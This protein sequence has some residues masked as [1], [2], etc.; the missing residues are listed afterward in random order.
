MKLYTVQ[1][2]TH[3]HEATKKGILTGGPSLQHVEPDWHK[4]YTWMREQMR[5]KLATMSGD[6]PVWAWPWEAY[7]ARFKPD[8][9]WGAVGEEM[10]VLGLDVPDARVLTSD[11]QAWHQVL[12]NDIIDDKDEF[13]EAE[14]LASW[15]LIFNPTELK[16]G[17]T[18]GKSV[19]ACVDQ[20][21]VSE[22]FF[23]QIFTVVPMNWDEVDD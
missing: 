12:N 14:M 18:D 11:F 16:K 4:A 15:Q 22:V 21:L 3:W 19:Q 2:L 1:G 5:L 9:R 10:V 23:V 20:V 6:Y 17:W 13:T 7:A 8:D